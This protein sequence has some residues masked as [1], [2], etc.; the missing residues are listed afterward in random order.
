MK[1]FLITFFVFFL[2]LAVPQTAN[3]HVLVTDKN[4]GAVMHIEPDDDPVAG[5]VS[6][7]ALDFQDK[8]GQFS[9]SDCACTF[10]IK[11]NGKTLTTQPL[12]ARGNTSAGAQFNFPTQDVYGLVI[13]GK[14]LLGSNFQSFSLTYDIRV[15]RGVSGQATTSGPK[16]LRGSYLI[17]LSAVGVFLVSLFYVIMTPKKE[18]PRG[19]K[20]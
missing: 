18:I 16:L 13:N 10:S 5:E 14:P 9:L 4:I 2:F 8:S 6:S 1:K 19:K 3:A 15:D 11:E 17:G 7:F 12:A 20:H